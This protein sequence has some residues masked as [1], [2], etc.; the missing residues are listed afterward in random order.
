MA[1]SE[2]ASTTPEAR[3]L[4]KLARQVLDIVDLRQIAEPHPPK[5][6]RVHIPAATPER[7]T[8]MRNAPV[9]SHHRPRCFLLAK[10]GVNPRCESLLIQRGHGPKSY[11]PRASRRSDV[12][13]SS[14]S[15][16]SVVKWHRGTHSVGGFSIPVIGGG[17]SWNTG[18]DE[19]DVVRQLVVR[20]S[21]RRVLSE[22]CEAEYE[23]FTNQSL[24]DI[25]GWIT[26][27]MTRLASRSEATRL[28][29][30]LRDG[31]NHYLRLTP[32]PR[33]GAPLRPEYAE[34]LHGLRETF[35]VIPPVPRHRRRN[36]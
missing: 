35:R 11:A 13:R 24:L 7:I 32:D 25:R 17:M 21:E 6:Q 23:A 20:L 12:S 3:Q 28:L 22:I 19:K 10:L 26:D 1:L 31:C 29:A 9:R 2:L 8:R 16:L 4:G 15:R 27:S 36:C 5:S 18:E 34:A 30:A 33:I 14:P